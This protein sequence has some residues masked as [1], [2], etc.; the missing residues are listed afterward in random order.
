MKLTT[1]VCAASAALVLAA[2]GGGGGDKGDPL[3]GSG[4][5]SGTSGTSTSGTSTTTTAG[6]S[7]SISLL[8]AAGQTTVL[9]QS[10]QTYT[11]S[12]ILKDG[13][14]NLLPNTLVTVTGADFTLTPSTGKVLTNSSGVA[15]VTVK[16]TDPA[17]SSASEIC[18]NATVGTA[19]L[20]NC[21]SVQMGAVSAQLGQVSASS[22]T[23]A[24]YQSIQVSVPVTVSNSST[25]A[26]GVPVSFS[27]SCGTFSPTT[28]NT[29]Q[30]GIASVSYTNSNSGSACSGAVVL[31]A[32]TSSGSATATVT[33]QAAV[34]ANIQFVSATPSKIYLKGSPG[35]GTSTVQFK[36]LN[37]NAG[38][39]AGATLQISFV[40]QP[41]GTSL[42]GGAVLPYEVTTDA[43]GLVSV[44]VV[45]GAAPGPLQLKAQLKDDPNVYNY[46][47]GLSVASGLP[48][49]NRFSLSASVLNIEGL[50]YD[51]VN[52]V[53]TVRAADRLGNPVPDGTTVNFISSGGQIVSSCVTSGASTG[54]TSGC[55]VTFS[56][57]DFR[58]TSG[59]VTVL[60]WAQGEES[61]VD[62]SSPSNNVFDAATD[63]FTD[64]GQPFLDANHDGAYQQGETMVGQ[65]SGTLACLGGVKSVP[66]TCDRAWGSAAVNKDIVIVLSGSFVDLNSLNVLRSDLGN[67]SCAYSFDLKD[68]NG[69][70]LPSGS[71]LAV[72]GPS[73]LTFDSFAG[74]GASVPNTNVAGGTSHVAIFTNC[75]GAG[76]EG[77]TLKV[78]TPKNNVSTVRLP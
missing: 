18:A 10:N 74:D 63:S 25:P 17:A 36:L 23:V 57:Q 11:A 28:A 75:S 33:A 45:A 22:S 66:N 49:Q 78:T 65:A 13:S 37:Q 38:P 39:M 40:Q 21:V 41:A 77:F 29:N 8:N 68:E 69:N 24:A 54:S 64:Q 53:L 62:N 48:T 42:Q 52:T 26:V 51:G 15:T 56:S 20:A 58:P 5:G 1:W 70:P 16:Q 31:T 4:S 14:G 7:I 76:S 30:A 46:S 59:R 32:S 50:G 61:F 44:S 2:C 6:P 12:V 19:S 35:P 73:G 3:Y 47:N 55:S 34:A 71:S 9:T 43:N 60:A 27:A 72:S 67:G